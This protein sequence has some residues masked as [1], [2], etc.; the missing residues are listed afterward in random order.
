M[1][2]LDDAHTKQGWYRVGITKF[3][4]STY[5]QVTKCYKTILLGKI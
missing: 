4:R 2:D 3:F 1:A 5:L